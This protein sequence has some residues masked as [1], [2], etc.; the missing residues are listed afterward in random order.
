MKRISV[1]E[2][3]MWMKSLEENRYKRIVEA[4]A[5]RVVWFINNKMN[6]EGMPTRISKKWEHT[7]YGREKYLA[8]KYIDEILSKRESISE[9]VLRKLIRKEIKRLG[10]KV[11]K[12]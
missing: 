12:A 6:E 8:Q 10:K 1:K 7:Q 11:Q 3:R 9:S 5:K 2:V 4:D